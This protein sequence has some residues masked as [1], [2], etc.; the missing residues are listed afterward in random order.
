ML[1]AQPE[2]NLLGIKIIITE[3]T[4]LS[5]TPSAVVKK[6]LEGTHFHCPMLMYK[7]DLGPVYCSVLNGSIVYA[8]TMTAGLSGRQAH[9]YPL[10]GAAQEMVAIDIVQTGAKLETIA[11]FGEKDGIGTF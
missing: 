9:S 11:K 5:S 8:Q 10:L 6:L 2:A 1:P 4:A 3:A 7:T